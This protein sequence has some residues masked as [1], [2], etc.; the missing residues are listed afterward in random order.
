LHQ[1]LT[2]DHPL[3]WGDRLPSRADIESAYGARATHTSL[4]MIAAAA[5]IE[6]DVTKALLAALADKTRPHDLHHR[7]KSPASL[8]RKLALYD[9]ADTPGRPVTD[10]LRYTVLTEHPASLVAA[11]RA[12]VTGLEKA[13]W[14]VAEVQHSYVEGSRYKGIHVDMRTHEGQRVEV[15]FHSRASADIKD[16]TTALYA[17]ARDRGLS[18]ATRAAAAAEGIRL[19]ATLDTPAGLPE[20]RHLGG[21]PVRSRRYGPVPDVVSRMPG[22]TGP[23]VGA[24]R[25]GSGERA[26]RT[27]GMGR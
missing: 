7:V 8:A 23:D 20:L 6:P 12:T 22:T 18:Q 16:R 24:E 3:D 10:V 5:A 4:A 17:V 2:G 15:Q 25:R 27:D 19:S 11:T 1:A 26:V 14:S 9:T 13:G 21:V